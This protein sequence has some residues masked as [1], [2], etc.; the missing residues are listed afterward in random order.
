MKKK[1]LRVLNYN[2]KNS[3]TCLTAYSPAIAKILDGNV[4]IILVG[5]SL[6]TTLYGMNNCR[7][8]TLDMMKIHGKAVIKNIKKSITVVDMPYKSYTNSSAL[9]TLNA[10]IFTKANML[11]LEQ[12][13]KY[14]F[15]KIFNE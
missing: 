9:K 15:R 12:I 1:I 5:D 11:K 10:L 3:I 2:F 6:G 8:V 7:N 4:N 14:P 13:R